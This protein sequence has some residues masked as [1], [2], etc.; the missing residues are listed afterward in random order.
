VFTASPAE[1]LFAQSPENLDEYAE[2]A[3][4]IREAGCPR[5]GL[6]L[7]PLDQ[8]YTLWWLLGA[9]ESGIRLEHVVAS[10]ATQGLIDPGFTPCAILCTDCGPVS[11][12]SDLPLAVD[13][14]H[15]RLYMASEAA[16]AP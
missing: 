15:I 10:E 12:I 7:R 1:I 13:Y 3:G 4:D 9:P 5:V 16:A 14:G 8:E 2:L 11:S 6:A